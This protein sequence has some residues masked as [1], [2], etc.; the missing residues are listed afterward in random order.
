MN[1]PSPPP[2][3]PSGSPAPSERARRPALSPERAARLEAT[4]NSALERPAV[5]R[6]AFVASECGDDADLQARVRELLAAHERVGGFLHD[7][8]PN[9]PE[10]EAELARLKPEEEGERI[11]PYK[12][13]EQVGEGGF[14]AVWVADQQEPVRRRVALKIIKMGMDTKEVIARF[15]Q[16]RQALAMMDHPNIA[17]V[18]DAGA[19]QHGRPYFVMEL[20]RG[21]KITDYCDQANLPTE[22]RL[23][24]F[25]QICHAVQHAHQKG[26]IHRDLKPSNIL[27]TLHD[28]VPVPK[29]ID[30]GIAKATESRLTEATVYTQLHQFIGTPAYMSPEQAEMSGLDIDTRSDIY[31]LGVLLYE[32]LAGSTPFDADELMASGIEAMRKAIRETDPMRPSTRLATLPGAELT[33]TAKRRSSETSKL[34]HEIKGDLDWIVMKCLEK[35]RS[36]RYETANGL[37][38]DLKRHL[39]NEPVVARPP[40]AAYRF[41]KAWKRNKAVYSAGMAVAGALLVGLAASLWQAGLAIHARNDAEAARISENQQKVAAEEE[42]RKAR[43]AEKAESAQRIEAETRRQESMSRLVRL[44]VANGTRL[45]EDGEYLS[46]LAW[47]VNA[48]D[49]EKD[50]PHRVEMHRRR[51]EALLLRSPKLVQLWSAQSDIEFEFSADARRCL[52]GAHSDDDPAHPVTEVRLWD[53]PTGE[54]V[55]PPLRFDGEMGRAGF[56][57]GDRAFFAVV[58]DELRLWDTATGLP[59]SPPMPFQQKRVRPVFSSDGAR[60][61]TVTTASGTPDSSNRDGLVLRDVRT[62]TPLLETIPLN[63]RVLELAPASGGNTFFADVAVDDLVEGRSYEFQ[64]QERSFD[65]GDLVRPI[66]RI[67]SSENLSTL[68]WWEGWLVAMG[69]GPG[70][71]RITSLLTGTSTSLLRHRVISYEPAFSPD[72]SRVVT[73]SFDGTARIWDARTGAELTPPLQHK[74]GVYR[75]EFS[76]DGSRVITGSWEPA[77]RIWNPLTGERIGPPLPHTRPVGAVAL[78]KYAT[79][80]LVTTDPS[81]FHVWNLQAAAG[82]ARELRHDGRVARITFRP[83]TSQLLTAGLDGKARLWEAKDGSRIREFDGH[84]GGIYDAAFSPDGGL[85]ATAGQDRAVRLWNP[86][87]GQEIGMPLLH[88]APVGHAEFSADGRMLLTA[89]GSFSDHA[90][91]LTGLKRALALKLN[92]GPWTIRVWDLSKGETVWDLQ[93][94]GGVLETRLSPDGNQIITAGLDVTVRAWTKAGGDVARKKRRFERGEI[95]A[96]NYSP[97]GK[98]IVVSLTS[99]AFEPLAAHVLDADTLEEVLPPLS[100]SDGVDYA[101][102]SSDG[103]KIATAGEDYGRVWDAE[104][105]KPLTSPLQSLGQ[106]HCIAFDARGETVVTSSSDGVVRVWDATTGEAITPPLPSTGDLWLDGI[107]SDGLQVAATG[108]GNEAWVWTLGRTGTPLDKVLIEAHLLSCRQLDATGTALEPISPSTLTDLWQQWR[109]QPMAQLIAPPSHTFTSHPLSQIARAGSDVVFR[110]AVNPGATPHFQ[111]QHD[112]TD[113][114]G[115]TSGTLTLRGVSVND[116]GSY[117]VIVHGDDPGTRRAIGRS[118]GLALSENGLVMGG[119]KRERY[120]GLPGKDLEVLTSSPAFPDHPSAVDWVPEF[121]SP[122]LGRDRY[123][124]RLTGFI[125]PQESADYEFM[126]AADDRGILYLSPDESAANKQAITRTRSWTMPR[127][128]TPDGPPGPDSNHSLLIKLEKGKRYYVEALLKEDEGGDHLAVTWKRAG[129]PTPKSGTAPIG[130]AFLAFPDDKRAQAPDKP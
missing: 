110:A 103:R 99:G 6:A 75:A 30:F 1:P 2:H 46:A 56:V 76:G 22:Q 121:E 118:A 119:L 128:W 63:G 64:I 12:L 41:Q 20:V 47:F 3:R 80:A 114:P 48:L 54:L 115:A 55:V 106:T 66:G 17:K 111:W 93:I 116:I 25:I 120:D 11:G 27:I 19:T 94:P 15:E 4:F 29:V 68:L 5:E 26:I 33:T 38:M 107:S 77:A 43:A 112:E 42:S 70:L 79:H 44:Q 59:V 23:E 102:F 39:H 18:L 14:G 74:S 71:T 28:G 82:D 113:I 60:V 53:T 101:C 37:A 24:L 32:L 83:G 58:A 91:P 96:I 35:D 117:R 72:G 69:E 85:L 98:R 109:G 100:H 13:R 81:S 9:S 73:P 88:Q 95:S 125:I 129:E 50:D 40:S 92:P 86:E 49:L 62:G 10:I 8:A 108:F 97:D 34:V 123:G 51:I 124:V 127:V 89:S 78:S 21:I 84:A 67:T 122:N 45:A 61:V 104:T 16:E 31:S 7:D 130:G 90:E 52:T 126:V 105:G 36:R 87:T 65:K 57:P